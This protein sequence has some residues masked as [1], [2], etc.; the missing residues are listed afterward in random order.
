MVTMMNNSIVDWCNTKL[1][2]WQKFMV[3]DNRLESHNTF[4]VWS[5]EQLERLFE[6]GVI[7]D[8]HHTV[9]TAVSATMG[10]S[11]TQIPVMIGDRNFGTA[12]K[13]KLKE[14]EWVEKESENEE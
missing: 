6:D 2:P 1:K 11:S 10:Y 5:V 13:V 12:N 7:D 14:N 9:F 4:P 3:R 8:T